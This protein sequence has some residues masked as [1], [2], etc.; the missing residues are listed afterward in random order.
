MKIMKTIKWI[1]NLILGTAILFAVQSS[2]YAAES[3]ADV[4]ANTSNRNAAYNGGLNGIFMF[5]TNDAYLRSKGGLFNQSVNVQF[6]QMV[7]VPASY[8]FDPVDG[9]WH[10]R[11]R[12]P[13]NGS[14]FFEVRANATGAV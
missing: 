11:L 8:T 5:G 7:G 2:A 3:V 4:G 9:D 14:T 1:R 13:N 12:A 6:S 10:L